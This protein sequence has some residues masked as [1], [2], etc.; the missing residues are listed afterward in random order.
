MTAEFLNLK[1]AEAFTGKSRSTLRRFVE[2]ITRT[3]KHPDRN[4]IEP[5]VDEVKKLHAANNPFAWRIKR[6]LLEREFRKQGSSTE[7]PIGTYPDSDRLVAVLEKSISMLETELK[8]KNVQIA[9]FQERQ[10]EFNVLLRSVNEQLAL[11]AAP[12]A[13]PAQDS[14]IEVVQAKE[15]PAKKSSP[16]K[17]R[18][19]KFW[20][21][22][23]SSN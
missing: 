15:T 13:A 6:E 12:K 19:K 16:P 9:Q 3:E 22:F 18:K 10:R 8:E 23:G 1:D 21:L 5:S 14:T 11:A 4:L 17:P 20:S 2:A 7:K